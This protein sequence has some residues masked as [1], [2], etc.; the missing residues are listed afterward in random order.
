MRIAV[1][2][3]I[4]G[5]LRALQAVLADIERRAP[6]MVVDLGDCVSGPL[7]AAATADLLMDRAFLTVRG[8]HDRQVVEAQS[9]LG[10]SDAAAAVQLDQRHRA[11]LASFPATAEIDGVL[12]CHGTP[13]HDDRYLLETVDAPEH[14]R[15]ASRAEVRERLGVPTHSIVLCGHSHT[16]RAV[17]NEGRLIVNPG[18]VGLQAFDHVDGHLHFIESGSPH[19]RYAV[20]ETGGQPMVEF[21]AVEYDWH[22]AAAD[23]AK[24]GR[25]DWAQGL[26][27]GYALRPSVALL[28]T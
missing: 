13:A 23:A 25:P 9:T 24:A 2:S 1:V 12:L 21:I 8:N 14:V 27:T 20:I 19:A 22:S 26:A 28:P 5:N 10:A 15:L 7:Q 17:R 16:A 11:W 18:S 6:D 3:D 4:H